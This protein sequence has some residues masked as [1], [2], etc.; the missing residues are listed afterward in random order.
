VAT[1]RPCSYSFSISF[2]SSL[3]CYSSRV[4]CEI[5]ARS[6]LSPNLTN[7]LSAGTTRA[8]WPPPAHRAEFHSLLSVQS[9]ISCPCLVLSDFQTQ[10]RRRGAHHLRRPP[11]FSPFESFSLESSVMKLLSTLSFI[12]LPVSSCLFL[13]RGLPSPLPRCRSIINTS[14][15]TI[16]C[17]KFFTM[18]QRRLGAE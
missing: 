6:P 18:I 9:S 12:S 7:S 1:V 10:I 17:L 11:P 3:L 5:G 2:T 4:W 15:W 8:F 14:H 13:S 16:T